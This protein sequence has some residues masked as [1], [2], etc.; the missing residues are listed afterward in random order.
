MAWKAAAKVIAFAFPNRASELQDHQNHITGPLRSILCT[1]TSS[2]MMWSFVVLLKESS[3]RCSQTIKNFTIYKSLFRR[4][5]AWSI[6]LQS[7]LGRRGIGNRGRIAGHQIIDQG[8]PTLWDE[9]VS[10]IQR[11]YSTTKASAAVTRQRCK[12]LCICNPIYLPPI[13]L[14]VFHFHPSLMRFLRP[15]L[16]P[17]L[18][19]LA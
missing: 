6:C 14:R 12:V 2:A 8:L 15:S 9:G 5:V 3:G 7:M 13:S 4:P 18:P 1:I 19:A 16:K 17:C 11:L 10:N